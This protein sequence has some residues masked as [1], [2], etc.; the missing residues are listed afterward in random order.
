MGW[1][2]LIAVAIAVL[3][4]MIAAKNRPQTAYLKWVAGW[5]KRDTRAS[6]GLA[7]RI[8]Q[9]LTAPVPG[10][11]VG[12]VEADFSGDG[13]IALVDLGVRLT[14]QPRSTETTW[15]AFWPALTG[16]VIV[17]DVGGLRVEMMGH[18]YVHIETRSQAV[19]DEWVSVLDLKG[20]PQRGS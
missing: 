3:P 4:V 19:R 17:G 11:V 1:L 2:V 6:T 9:V 10:S 8:E 14:D 5:A 13:Y 18:S 12:R 20:V 16:Y 15:G 7:P